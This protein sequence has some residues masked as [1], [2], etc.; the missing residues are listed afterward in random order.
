MKKFIYIFVLLLS[1]SL[2][3]NVLENFTCL[4]INNQNNLN[5]PL[6]G[7]FPEKI[8]LVFNNE[9]KEL[10]NF[11]WDNNSVLQYFK[12]V[13]FASKSKIIEIWHKDY[14]MTLKTDDIVNGIYFELYKSDLVAHMYKQF[15]SGVDYQ[16]HYS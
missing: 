5:S 4:K 11:Y 3:A 14:Q 7:T 13:S 15:I 8:N 16:C 12:S 2:Q 9:S 10:I 6:V 1:T